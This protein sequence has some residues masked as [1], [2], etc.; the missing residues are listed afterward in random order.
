MLILQILLH[1]LLVEISLQLLQRLKGTSICMFLNIHSHFLLTFSAV[2]S[3][4]LDL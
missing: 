4:S 3:F 1:I 2:D